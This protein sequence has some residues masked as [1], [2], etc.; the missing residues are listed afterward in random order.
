MTRYPL[1]VMLR[2]GEYSN[3]KVHLVYNHLQVVYQIMMEVVSQKIMIHILMQM[4]K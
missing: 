1:M 2:I 4:I 3:S